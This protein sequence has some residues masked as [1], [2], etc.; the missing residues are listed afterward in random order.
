[1]FHIC[2]SNPDY[3]SLWNF[4]RG[5]FTKYSIILK[6]DLNHFVL[7]E[8][9]LEMYGSSINLSKDKPDTMVPFEHSVGSSVRDTELRLSADGIVKNSKSC[10]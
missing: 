5:K 3:L 6:L 1:M 2:F 4:R 8:I 7:V 9:L 10:K